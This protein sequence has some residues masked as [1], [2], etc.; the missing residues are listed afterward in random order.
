MYCYNCNLDVDAQAKKEKRSYS[1]REHHF[2]IMEEVFYCPNC[3]LELVDNL[4]DDLAR[5]YDGYLNLFGL[6]LSSFKKIRE[7]L[8]LDCKRFAKALG[9]AYKSI[10][11]Y[12]N[13]ESIPEGEYLSVYIKLHKNKDYILEKAALE[14]VCQSI[15]KEWGSIDILVNGAGGNHPRATT[16]DEYYDILNRINLKFDIKSRNVILYILGKSPK[17]IINIVKTL[18]AIDFYSMKERGK[19]ITKFKYVKMQYGP[20]IDK[21]VDLFND[22]SSL[23][24]IKI[25][26]SLEINGDLKNQYI[27]NIN[28]DK[29]LFTKEELELIDYVLMKTEGKSAKQLSDWSHYFKGWIDTDM[30]KEINMKKYAKY[31]DINNL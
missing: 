24:E 10:Y 11:R 17:H 6:S 15:M 2:S 1:Y 9:W 19:A 31:F 30:G 27:N 26:D 7:S 12:E 25:Y 16:N 14:K 23:D 3:G 21:Y 5:I 22:M 20:N 28:F 29:D 8:H 13:G 18:F 4:D